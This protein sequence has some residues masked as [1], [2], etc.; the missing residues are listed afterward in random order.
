VL[1]GTDHGALLAL[2]ESDLEI[3][4][5]HDANGAVTSP[6]VFEDS[7]V[8]FASSDRTVHCLKFKSGKEKWRGRTGATCTASPVVRGPYLYVMSYD[9]DIYVFNKKNGHQLTRVRMGHRLDADAAVAQNHLL[10]VPF[11]EASVVGLALPY[12][13]K[14]GHFDLQA[15]GEWFTTSPLLTR[16]R[17]ALGYGR[18]EGR[19]VALSFTEKAA[20]PPGDTKPA[21]E[22]KPADGTGAETGTTSPRR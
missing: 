9:N 17:V 2:R 16:D 22:A 8:W 21:P 11:T 13:Q 5:R 3:L 10:V 7:R 15:P 19:I 6:P 14:V 12:L 1:I 4:F 20:P 18:T